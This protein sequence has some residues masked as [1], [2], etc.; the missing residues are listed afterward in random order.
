MI[1]FLKKNECMRVGSEIW[2]DGNTA[3]SDCCKNP[4]TD[5][6]TSNK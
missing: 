3:N 4:G 2:N 6:E 5:G 1:L